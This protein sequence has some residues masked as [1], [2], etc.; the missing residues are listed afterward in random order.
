MT[1]NKWQITNGFHK[2]A[3][4]A[5][6]AKFKYVTHPYQLEYQQPGKRRGSRS[7]KLLWGSSFRQI[8]SLQP[9]ACFSQCQIHTCVRSSIFSPTAHL[10]RGKY[11]G[12]SKLWKHALW[13]FDKGVWNNSLGVSNKLWKITFSIVSRFYWLRPVD[14]LSWASISKNQNETFLLRMAMIS[15]TWFQQLSSIVWFSHKDIFSRAKM[16]SSAIGFFVDLFLQCRV[17]IWIFLD[18]FVQ[19]QEVICARYASQCQLECL[20]L[21]P[22]SGHTPSLLR[23]DKYKYKHKHKH[24]HK[25]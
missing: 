6:A 21:Q 19:C 23:K 25:T 9:Y 4:T 13:N 1:K 17:V 12:L 2:N 11:L 16:L 7:A 3:N 14:V 5:R 8:G 10:R 18:L 22:S 20:C 24:K 15:L